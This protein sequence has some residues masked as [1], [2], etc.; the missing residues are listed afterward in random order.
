MNKIRKQ[1]ILESAFKGNVKFYIY[2]F[3]L[4]TLCLPFVIIVKSYGMIQ[5][6]GVLF[7]SL[8]LF[9]GI[10]IFFIKKGIIKDGNGLQIGYF[11]WRKLIYTE[12]ISLM[13]M[14]V[15]T[16]LNFRKKR[17]EFHT[18][19][20]SPDFSV[21]SNSFEIYLLNNKHTVKRKVIVLNSEDKANAAMD[22]LSKHSKL[23]HEIY[24]PD[25]T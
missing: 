11:S 23:R 14:Q 3:F 19:V 20:T 10:S 2:L 18:D 1:I 22:F 9:V 24:S 16:L 8:I 13:N 6:L 15:V 4:M 21:S 17:R 12:P 25:F 7:F 5:V